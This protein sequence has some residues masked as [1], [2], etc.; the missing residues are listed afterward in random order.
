MNWAYTGTVLPKVKKTK[1]RRTKN[2]EAVS[3]LEG[4]LAGRY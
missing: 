2:Q 1:K 4:M 3:V